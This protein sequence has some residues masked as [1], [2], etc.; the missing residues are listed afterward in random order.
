MGPGE[1]SKRLRVLVLVEDLVSI[2]RTD[3]VVH[4]HLKLQVWGSESPL[5]PFLT[6]IGFLIHAVP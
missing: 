2:P 1:M 4:N 3:R 6:L 5:P